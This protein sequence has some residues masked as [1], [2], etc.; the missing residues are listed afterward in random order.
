MIRQYTFTVQEVSSAWDEKHHVID[1]N[2]GDIFTYTILGQDVEILAITP[3]EKHERQYAIDF[4]NGEWNYFHA[5][6][7]I[8]VTVVNDEVG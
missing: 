3:S 1:R 6:D 5:Y 8:L 4:A 7:S 2:P